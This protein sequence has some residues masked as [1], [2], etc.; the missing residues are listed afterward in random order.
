MRADDSTAAVE[1][2]ERALR[3]NPQNRSAQRGLG[4]AYLQAEDHVAAV[5]TWQQIADMERELLRLGQ[6]EL[7]VFSPEQDRLA[8]VYQDATARSLAWYDLSI[9]VDSS[10][11]DQWYYKGHLLAEQ[12]AWDQAADAYRNGLE[13]TEAL[14][15][16]AGDLLFRLAETFEQR[17]PRDLDAAMQNY[18]KAIAQ[19]SYGIPRLQAQAHYQRAEIFREWQEFDEATTAY[20]RVIELRPKDYWTMTRLATLIYESDASI[21]KA[22]PWLFRAIELDDAPPL[23]Y[24]L[25]GQLYQQEERFA[26]AKAMYEAALERRPDDAISLEQIELVKERLE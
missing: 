18:K 10:L 25:L 8:G 17:Q 7:R 6:Q 24:R 14:Q 23:A 19:D 11:R 4:F 22:E 16:Q 1:W 2:F 15:I 5:A 12:Q 3:A 21:T 20:E 9:Q 26:D 13:R